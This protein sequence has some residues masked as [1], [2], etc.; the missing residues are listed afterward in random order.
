LRA[1][2]WST[3]MVQLKYMAALYRMV[4]HRENI[5][6]TFTKYG[7]HTVQPHVNNL[8]YNLGIIQLIILNKQGLRCQNLFIVSADLASP[9]T[10]VIS[11]LGMWPHHCQTHWAHC[12]KQQ[13][14]VP[15]SILNISI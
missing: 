8:G 15:H 3:S 6:Y 10:A 12:W 2:L 13:T 5:L 9:L 7:C 14:C 1:C 4:C 11:A